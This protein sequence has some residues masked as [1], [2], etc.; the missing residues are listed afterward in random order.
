MFYCSVQC[1][2][3]APNATQ[4]ILLFY[5]F[6]S[7][8]ETK[9]VRRAQPWPAQYSQSVACSL[10][11]AAGNPSSVNEDS[12]NLH[13]RWRLDWAGRIWS[14]PATSHHLIVWTGHICQAELSPCCL[15]A[16][17]GIAHQSEVQGVSINMLTSITRVKYRVC[18][19]RMAMASAVF[20]PDCAGR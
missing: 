14:S 2:V 5:F 15:G 1:V 6:L 8:M 20:S 17:A 10:R 11:S 19:T 12:N 9:L 16:A 13:W 18:D 4:T 3:F 7:T